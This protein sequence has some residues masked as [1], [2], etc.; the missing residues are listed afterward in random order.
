M[1]C[2]FQGCKFQCLTN[3]NTCF[4]HRN[5][6]VHKEVHKSINDLPPELYFRI[7]DNMNMEELL[8]LYKNPLNKLHLDLLKEYYT[9][10]KLKDFKTHRSLLSLINRN[11]LVDIPIINIDTVLEVLKKK[12]KDNS[13]SIKKNN[14][15]IIYLLHENKIRNKKWYKDGLKHIIDGPALIAYINGQKLIEVW[16]IDGLKH[17]IDEPAVITYDEHGI[18]IM[19]E[20]YKDGLA[21][22][23]DEP[24]VIAYRNVQIKL[25]EICCVLLF[26]I[27]FFF[28][29][30][31]YIQMSCYLH[32][33][34]ITWRQLLASSIKSWGR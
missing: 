6:E 8:L 32:Y 19:E 10:E 17:R 16:Y 34:N 30:V 2:N 13:I 26:K 5:K 11:D 31:A 28:I 33:N 22:R 29:R 14:I 20:W 18:I 21:H 27:C 1:L 3:K 25:Y 23:I 4:L 24:A 7:F 15:E 12:T 9:F